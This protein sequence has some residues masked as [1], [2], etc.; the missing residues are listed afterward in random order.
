M[1]PPF[2]LWKE[3]PAVSPASSDEIRHFAA[4]DILFQEGEAADTA[5]VIESGKVS[6]FKNGRGGGT[7]QLGTMGQS[8]LIGESG[9]LDKGP[10][11]S[12]AR[13]E[14]AVSVR[15]VP[16]AE[17]IR[18]IEKDPQAALRIMTRMAK[19][20]RDTDERLASGSTPIT[21]SATALVPVTSAP[22]PAVVA[23]PV[24]PAYPPFSQTKGGQFIHRLM[25]ALRGETPAARQRRRAR[26]VIVSPLSSDPEYDQRPYLIEALSGIEHLVVK[27]NKTPF[28]TDSVSLSGGDNSRLRQFIADE[29]AEVLIWG[30]EDESGSFLELHFSPAQE[31]EHER[32]GFFPADSLLIIPADFDENWGP[33]LKG[34]TL[35]AINGTPSVEFA[36]LPVLAERAT[37]LALE[38]P[39]TLE[40]RARASLRAMFGHLAAQ[41]GIAFRRPALLE[42]AIQ[43][44]EGC[45]SDL[46][47][48][49]N[50]HWGVVNKS[51][52]FLL[53]ARGEKNRDDSSLRRAVS[54]LRQAIEDMRPEENPR[55]WGTMHARVGKMLFRLDLK[56]GDDKVLKDSLS[57]YQTAISAFPRNRD[58]W[59]WAELMNSIAKVL[60]V[61]GDNLKSIEILKKTVEMCRS[62]LEVRTPEASPL[63]YAASRNNMGSGLFLLAKHTNDVEYMRLAAVAFR[64]AL[65]IHRTAS[66]SGILAETISRNLER[67]ERLLNRYDNRRV[68]EPSWANESRP[69]V[70]MEAENPP[71]SETPEPLSVPEEPPESADIVSPS[72]RIMPNPSLE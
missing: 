45:L 49:E 72:E 23:T 36:A 56:T 25:G 28:P 21:D 59:K 26:T 32:P 60:Q 30:G 19:R 64:D 38:P 2:S 63:L 67:T 27:D 39:E 57:H 71:T 61:Y 3:M 66:R 52:G 40:A 34:L 53:Q 8:E 10:R 4:G 14:T 15:V 31:S 9:V 51:L 46:P 29:K 54:A 5:F 13:A 22:P 1:P 16:R 68:A 42:A 48:A 17:F 20:L 6:L 43:S 41:A 58:P 55:A 35:A 62:T 47:R 11:G 37:T 18:M 33:L 12:S 70:E 65:A 44:Y 50:P 7:V 24:A 69:E